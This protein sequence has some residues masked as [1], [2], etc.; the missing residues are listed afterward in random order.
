MENN[1]HTFAVFFENLGK[2]IQFGQK[3]APF[4][5]D[6]RSINRRIT[7]ILRL[8]RGDKLVFF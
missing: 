4:D 8:R 1:K 2:Y 6:D 5:L 3:S 7:N